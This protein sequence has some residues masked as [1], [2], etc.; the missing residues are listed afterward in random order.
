M[1]WIAF[2]FLWFEI[3]LFYE[4]KLVLLTDLSPLFVKISVFFPVVI[5]L[6]L[7]IWSKNPLVSGKIEGF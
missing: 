4:Y 6:N 1:L 3:Y 5:L 2:S 7:E